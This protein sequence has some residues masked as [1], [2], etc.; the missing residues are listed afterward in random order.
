MKVNILLAAYNGE[1]FIEEQIA[2][3]QAQT[4]SDW[5]LLVRDDGSS[6]QTR[7]LVQQLAKKDSRIRL[8]DDDSQENLGVIKSFHRLMTYEEADYYFFSDQDD[9]WVPE[10]VALCLEAAQGY[11]LDHPLLVYTDLKVV[12]QDLE[13]LSESMIRSQS[14][15]PNTQLIQ[16]LTENTVTGGTMM[17][18]NS[19][20]R[21]WKQTEG[22]LMHDWYLAL[23]ASSLGHLIYLDQPTEL[24]RQHDANVLGARTLTKRIQHWIRPHRLV[25]KY[26]ALIT[27]SQ[28]QA[29]PLLDLPLPED[30]YELV[31]AYLTLLDGSLLA[32]Y[33]RLKH[34][35]F[36]KNR[37]FHTLVF[38]TLVVTKFGYR[39]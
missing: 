4:F 26:W 15:H 21:Y 9:I 39:S 28:K 37:A 32:R 27:N 20:A 35:G 1:R 7:A 34:F 38:W 13:V 10:K 11:A 22:I 12:N 14:G 36:R 25:Q 29:E 17:I 16:E 31:Q 19:L 6:D 24:Y 2:S 8:I 23:L 18:S 5:T 33:K 30:K 3:I